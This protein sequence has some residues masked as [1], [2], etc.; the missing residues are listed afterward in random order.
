MHSGNP[1]RK[2]VYTIT[3]NHSDILNS[4]KFIS[5]EIEAKITSAC[6][7]LLAD[8]DMVYSTSN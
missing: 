5:C 6:V 7:L 1:I 8:G 4:C 2:K 3:I